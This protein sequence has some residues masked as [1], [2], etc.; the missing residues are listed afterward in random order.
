MQ[1]KTRG[2]ATL[3]KRAYSILDEALGAGHRETLAAAARMKNLGIG[4]VTSV[5]VRHPA[6][7]R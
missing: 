7:R 5:P 6:A 3:Y 2:A 4:G 1:G